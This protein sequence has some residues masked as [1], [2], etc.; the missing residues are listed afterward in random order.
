MLLIAFWNA[1]MSK[2]NK[3]SNNIAYC[4]LI[5]FSSKKGQKFD[6]NKIK[7]L[8][9]YNQERGT[10]ASG[11]WTPVNGTH[12]TT[13]KA[14]KFLATKFSEITPDCSLIGHVRSGTSYKTF[15]SAAHPFEGDNCVLAHNGTLTNTTALA[16]KYNL[17]QTGTDTEL[18]HKIMEGNFNNKILTQIDGTASL[19]VADKGVKLKRGQENSFLLAFRLNN[20]RPLFYGFCEEGMYISSLE[21]SLNAINCTDIKEFDTNTLYTIFE[22]GI[23]NESKIPSRPIKTPYAHANYG[24]NN[25]NTYNNTVASG[26]SPDYWLK[27]VDNWVQ[28]DTLNNTQGM[29]Y[30]RDD[31]FL[32]KEIINNQFL[33]VENVLGEEFQIPFRHFYYN[34]KVSPLKPTLDRKVVLMHQV[35][36]TKGQKIVGFAGDVLTSN[37]T[38]TIKDGIRCITVTS[39][40]DGKKYVIDTVLVRPCLI[41]EEKLSNVLNN[42][43]HLTTSTTKT[44]EKPQT[45]TLQTSK[46]DESFLAQFMVEN[47]LTKNYKIQQ[48][49]QST[50][51]SKEV[52]A[53][54]DICEDNIISINDL[55]SKV[56]EHESDLDLQTIKMF[57]NE[58]S[59]MKEKICETYVKAVDLWNKK[60]EMLL[61]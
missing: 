3:N 44:E 51:E 10:D 16:N 60:K 30:K 7:L 41:D 37:L 45:E 2:L 43:I 52:S 25:F 35:T 59:S 61:A 57:K 24:H 32:V 27:Y 19:L 1:L 31:W 29:N 5:G 15:V 56:E 11:I 23:I 21:E 8:F 48:L 40:V 38:E 12:K 39:L 28:T 53:I 49:I 58:F 9:M 6:I 47:C 4:G 54:F 33:K 22:G 46:L 55:I 34:Q 14:S 36:T 20:E 18:L 50:D 17:T 13:D 26:S 42:S